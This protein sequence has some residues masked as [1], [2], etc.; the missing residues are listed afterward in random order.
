MLGC[1]KT[2]SFFAQLPVAQATRI[3]QCGRDKDGARKC[4]N[5][6]MCI[7]S[8]TAGQ[9]A[10]LRLTGCLAAALFATSLR[11]SLSSRR[12]PRL[13]LCQSRHNPTPR[14]ASASEE[15]RTGPDPALDLE[16]VLRRCRQL[17][18]VD[19][20]TVL[21]DLVVLVGIAPALAVFFARVQVW[22]PS[23]LEMVKKGGESGFIFPEAAHAVAFAACWFSVGLAAGAFEANAVTPADLIATLRRTWKPGGL[24]FITAIFLWLMQSATGVLLPNYAAM[25]FETQAQ[26]CP[27]LLDFAIDLQFSLLCLGAWRFTRAVSM[28]GSPVEDEKNITDVQLLLGDIIVSGVIVPN[29]IVAVFFQTHVYTPGW[30]D[31][32]RSDARDLS[33]A[34]L[35][36]GASLCLCWLS[37]AFIA[38]G[39]RAGAVN[40]QDLAGTLKRTWVVGATATAL[41][42]MITALSS[43]LSVP[44]GQ[45]VPEFENNRRLLNSVLDLVLDIQFS[46]LS[47]TTWRLVYSGLL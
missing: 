39:Y 12:V 10:T 43:L 9:G 36:H 15:S 11:R 6:S 17:P 20:W 19:F 32:W 42:L 2:H 8:T 30:L 27:S 45:A 40:R 26:V 28:T 35:A 3:L 29:I 1:S 14:R 16:T 4:N 38:G 46:A 7:E 34:T 23:W 22:T 13:H 31:F 41:L 37:A 5:I 33:S 47:L 44:D 24:T 25:G 18:N 21:G